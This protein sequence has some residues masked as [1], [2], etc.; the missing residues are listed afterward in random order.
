MQKKNRACLKSKDGRLVTDNKEILKIQDS[1]YSELYTSK[2]IKM[3]DDYLEGMDLK[4]ITDFQRLD[5][6]SMITESEIKKAVFSM[7][8]N[9]VA[10]LDGLPV[11]FYQVF[12][13]NIQAIIMQVIKKA[14]E[15]GFPK[16]MSQGLITLI[17][18]ANKDLLQI[19]HWRPISLLCIDCKILSKVLANRLYT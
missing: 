13:A 3:T 4:R 6:D 18:K 11:E 17:E 2:K 14:A 5:L 19:E 9:K 15:Q 7:P 1:F 16:E 12:W 10:G 8:P